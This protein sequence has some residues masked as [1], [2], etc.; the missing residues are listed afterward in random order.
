MRIILAKQHKKLTQEQKKKIT[1]LNRLSGMFK[2]NGGSR[3][4]SITKNYHI[5]GKTC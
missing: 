5:I 3:I 2:V 4:I 1:A